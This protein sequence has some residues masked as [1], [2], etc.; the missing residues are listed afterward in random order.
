M[1]NG[2]DPVK[3]YSNKNIRCSRCIHKEYCQDKVKEYQN[4]M[5]SF[6][7]LRPSYPWSDRQITQEE[8][9]IRNFNK[10]ISQS[11]TY[12]MEVQKK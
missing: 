6:D 3:N 12:L 1:I 2:C 9:F 7:P 4:K 10:A 11:G 5:E 8:L